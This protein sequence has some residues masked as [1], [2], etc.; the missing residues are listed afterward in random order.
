MLFFARQRP[1]ARLGQRLSRRLHRSIQCFQ[2]SSAAAPR[3]FRVAVIGSGPAGFYAAYRLMG[4]V[5]EAI[6]DMYEQLPVPFGLVR[7]G[8]A[9]DH[10]EVKNCQDKFTEVATSPRFNFIG[11]IELGGS[12]P[13]RSLKPHYDAVLFSYGAS[14]DR[15]L[16]LPNERSLSGIFSARA[17]VGW[18]NGLPEYRNLSPDL[19]S[20]EDAVIIGQ[21]NV[22]LDVA[23][24][25]L[26][27]VDVLRKTDMSE[28]AL[29]ELAKSRVKRVRVVGRRGPMQAAFTIKEVRELMQLPLVGFEPI[30]SN[31]LPPDSIIS[32]LPRANK[33]ITQLLAK[34]SPTSLE[35]SAK[36]WSLDFLLSPRSFHSSSENPGRLSH[37]TFSRNQLDPADPYSPSASI[38]PHLADDGKVAHIDIS[39]SLCFRS[40]GYKAC[41]LP[42]LDELAVPFDASRG[43]IPN[44]GQGRVLTTIPS[45]SEGDSVPTHVPGVYC[46]GW[47]KRGPTGVIAATMTDAFATADAIA[48]DWEVHRDRGSNKM[49]FLNSRSGEE[50]TGLGWD[51]VR[52]DAEKRGLWPTSWKDW[53]EIDRVER[54]R[55]Q[56]RG[57]PR[58]KFA[59]VD[60][61]L[62]V[63]A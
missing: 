26:S 19:A 37:I 21:G 14:K 60:D 34:G 5:P 54:D 53:E 6:V 44:D 20:G 3:S 2:Y 43:L 40:I 27:D 16:G 4:K 30:A 25:L 33:R 22:A 17:F 9:P 31:L 63:L 56:T 29:E 10:P 42:G 41:P 8:V 49:E 11:N 57:K 7:Y 38:S 62:G 35:S 12:L 52:P 15:E 50:S 36:K 13:L 18:Y 28:Y 47:V 24:V 58:E 46:A 23:R 55:G 39:A 59:L 51:G 45:A 48:A 61:M 1:K 32:G